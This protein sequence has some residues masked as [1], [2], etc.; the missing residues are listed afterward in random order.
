MKRIEHDV[1]EP[2]IGLHKAKTRAPNSFAA[3]AVVGALF[4]TASTA[5][6][7]EYADV[8]SSTP[9]T[10]Q[11]GVPTQ[12]CQDVP[13]AYTPPTSG[14]G[15]VLG[16]VAGAVLGNSVGGGAGRALATGAG[17]IGGAVIGDRVEAN[18][19]QP[20]TVMSR[21]CQNGMSYESR[22]V[23]YDV[24]YEYHGQRYTARLPQDPGKRLALNVNVS[25]AGTSDTSSP[26]GVVS[27]GADVPIGVPVGDY[28]QPAPVYAPAPVYYPAQPYYAAPFYAPQPSVWVQPSLFI[29]FGGGGGG[30]GHWR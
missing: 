5:F 29:G 14:I 16:T 20:G 13:Q 7:A 4:M 2:R 18:G 12:Q 3:A 19:N 22:V 21:Q 28:A 1:R 26:Q 11:F 23:G 27:Q 8:I 17:A 15:A 10:G 30:R 25:P 6:A 9:V 24:T